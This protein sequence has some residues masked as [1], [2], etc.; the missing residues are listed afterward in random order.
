MIMQKGDTVWISK[1]AFSFGITRA[2]IR[3]IV[4]K[5]G[6]II[7]DKWTTFNPGEFH[8]TLEEAQTKAKEM[9]ARKLNSLEKQAAKLKAIIEHGAKVTT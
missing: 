7:T 5:T 1:Y 9:A 2:T 4:I 3:D 8:T 6:A